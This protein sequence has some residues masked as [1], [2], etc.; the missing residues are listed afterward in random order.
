MDSSRTSCA[1]TVGMKGFVTPLHPPLLGEE[2][3]N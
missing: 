1:M 3:I 2:P